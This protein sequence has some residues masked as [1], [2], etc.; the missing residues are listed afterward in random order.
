MNSYRRL[1][2]FPICLPAMSTYLLATQTS[3]TTINGLKAGT[4]ILL[5]T[6]HNGFRLQYRTIDYAEA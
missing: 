3:Y 6:L 1:V 2:S 4:A 5:I